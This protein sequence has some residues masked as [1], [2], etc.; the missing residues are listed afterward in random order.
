MNPRCTRKEFEED[1]AAKDIPRNQPRRFLDAGAHFQALRRSHSSLAR[2][3]GED[4]KAVADQLGQGIG[5]NT[6]VYT[7]TPIER[8]RQGVNQRAYGLRVM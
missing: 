6:D 3:A 5:V 1:A 8:R 2:A 7:V 4:P